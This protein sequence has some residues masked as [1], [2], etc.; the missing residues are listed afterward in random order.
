MLLALDERISHQKEI[1]EPTETV[2]VVGFLARNC[3]T[4]KK[5]IQF[6]QRMGESTVSKLKKDQR[7][8]G[9][10]KKGTGFISTNCKLF[11]WQSFVQINQNKISHSIWHFPFFL[12]YEG[13]RRQHD[14]FN[15][16]LLLRVP[17]CISWRF[18]PRLPL[19][20]RTIW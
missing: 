18:L 4:E 2:K 6:S 5:K 16:D 15:W 9:Q 11:Y 10:K 13:F 14:K 7:D 12:S 3:L 20:C 19:N 17:F 1:K 8:Q